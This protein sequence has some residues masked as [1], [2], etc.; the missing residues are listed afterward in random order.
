MQ[1]ATFIVRAARELDDLGPRSDRGVA[2]EHIGRT[3]E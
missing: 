1:C 3:N 2:V